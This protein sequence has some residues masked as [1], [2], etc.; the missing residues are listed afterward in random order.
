MKYP[1]GTQ[2]FSTIIEE[3]MVYVDKTDFV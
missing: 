1:I 3:G 2:T